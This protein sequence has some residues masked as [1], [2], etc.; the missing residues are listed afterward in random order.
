MNVQL[1]TE[2]HLEFLSL[3]GGCS[4]SSESTL[5]KIPQCWKS[6]VTA[7]LC[8]LSAIYKNEFN[9]K[10]QYLLYILTKNGVVICIFAAMSESKG[11]I[12]VKKTSKCA[13]TICEVATNGDFCMLEN[14]SG[15]KV[16]LFPHVL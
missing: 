5:V 12:N 16:R 9:F 3:K 2:N 8:A 10:C 11:T 1:L 7:H 14:T 13:V 6:R 4:G 15:A